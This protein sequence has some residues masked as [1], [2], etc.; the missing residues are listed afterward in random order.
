MD[1]CKLTIRCHDKV[2]LKA[3]A[4]FKLDSSPAQIIVDNLAPELNLDPQIA[5]ALD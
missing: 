4:R 3:L 5:G 1:A 2:C